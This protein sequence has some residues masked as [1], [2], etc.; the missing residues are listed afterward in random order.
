MATPEVQFRDGADSSLGI[1]PVGPPLCPKCL[2][3]LTEADGRL[4]CETCGEYE[5]NVG[6]D[7]EDDEEYGFGEV[8]ST[9]R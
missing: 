5:W 2:N 6:G 9:F 8:D 3:E 1:E 7:N 4:V